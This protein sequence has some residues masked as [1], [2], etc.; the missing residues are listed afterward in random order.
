MTAGAA[1]T[2]DLIGIEVASI[3][4]ASGT[5]N[6]AAI[7]VNVPSGATNNYSLWV[8]SGTARFD[9]D[10]LL[11]QAAPATPTANVIYTDSIVKGWVRFNGTGVIAIDDDLNVTSL[12][13][14]GVGDYT[15][16]WA[17]A[18]ASANYSVTAMALG[19]NFASRSSSA[20][21]TTTA[22][23]I[24]VFDSAGAAAD[25]AYVSVQ[26]IGDQ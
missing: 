15:V 19:T 6:A 20:D 4:A 22:A 5:T 11:Q 13:D 25:S 8:D 23:R 24:T 14:N 16:N 1:T 2:T 21:L 18:F 10:L 26:A 9:A 17:T 7:R 12:T 3:V